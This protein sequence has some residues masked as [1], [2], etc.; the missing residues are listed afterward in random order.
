M[1]TENNAASPIDAWVLETLEEI[2]EV[3]NEEYRKFL[4][5]VGSS[6]GQLLTLPKEIQEPPC[7]SPTDIKEAIDSMMNGSTRIFFDRYGGKSK[8]NNLKF[9]MMA[10]GKVTSGIDNQ[11]PLLLRVNASMWP[12][13][14][15]IST[16]TGQTIIRN[17]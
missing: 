15:S 10:D 17:L 3:K 12:D 13:T 8:T 9:I 5:K 2:G 16:N 1:Q 4:E 7:F 14:Y 11:L 6:V